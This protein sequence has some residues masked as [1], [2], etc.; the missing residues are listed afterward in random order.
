MRL[1]LLTAALLMSAGMNASADALALKVGVQ[2][3]DTEGDDGFNSATQNVLNGWVAFEHPV[4]IVPNIKVR[5]AQFDADDS[6]TNIQLQTADYILYYELLDNPVLTFDLGLGAHHVRSGELLGQSFE[7]A[8]PEVYASARFPFFD[9]DEGLGM[10]VEGVAASVSDVKMTDLQAGISYSFSLSAIDLHLM[11]GYRKASYE[12][13]GFD[14]IISG[15]QNFD[16]VTVGFE[17]DI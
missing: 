15:E 3:W 17:L 2:A 7:G 10:Y 16:G 9:R 5:A 11:A 8:M 14:D 6:G 12:Y 13:D 1:K 4:P